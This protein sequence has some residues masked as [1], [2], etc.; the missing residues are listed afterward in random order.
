MS[1]PKPQLYPASKIAVGSVLYSCSA[2]T[3]DNGKTSTSINEWVVR[4]IKARRGTKT[5]MG[6]PVYSYRDTNKYVNIT[7]KI[8]FVTWVKRSSKIGDYGWSKSIPSYCTKQFSV[9]ACLPPGIYT[10]IRAAVLYGLGS[11]ADFLAS[12]KQ[13]NPG[14]RDADDEFCIAALEAEYAALKRRFAKLN[15]GKV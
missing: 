9:G 11:T 4:S 1:T 15:A 10:T 3:D 2:W 6:F 8:E 13:V 7:R 14:G 12:C 5:R